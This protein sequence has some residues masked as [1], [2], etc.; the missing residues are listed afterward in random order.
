[1]TEAADMITNP[2]MN[3]PG[4]VC[5]WRYNHTEGERERERERGKYRDGY[6]Y[7]LACDLGVADGGVV[8]GVAMQHS[9]QGPDHVLVSVQTVGRQRTQ[10]ILPGVVTVIRVIKVLAAISVT[11]AKIHRRERII[12]AIR[13]I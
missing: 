13:S 5:E 11:A 2:Y 6:I 10:H 7:V 9:V 8:E 12:W 1:M 4:Y 3:L